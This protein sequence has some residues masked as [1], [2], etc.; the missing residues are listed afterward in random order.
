MARSIIIQMKMSRSLSLADDQN[1][2]GYYIDA[3][4]KIQSSL[5]IYVGEPID[6]HPG[7]GRQGTLDP[8]N[9]DNE[10]WYKFTACTGQT[11]QVSISTTG[12]FA[13]ELTDSAGDPVGQTYT[14]DVNRYLFCSCLR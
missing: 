2:M 6:N 9:G 1:D 5:E 14:A 3:K 13:V 10:D 7:R 8:A 4:D 11:I 12:S